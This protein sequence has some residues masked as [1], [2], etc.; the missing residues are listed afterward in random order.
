MTAPHKSRSASRAFTL[1]E[2]LVVISIIALLIGITFPALGQ[3]RES[4]R[5]VKCLANLR[6]IGQGVA[7]YMDRSKGLLPK[8]RPLLDVPVNTGRP[9]DP[10][11]TEILPEYLDVEVPRK[12]NQSDPNSFY[13]TADVFKCPSDRTSDS[14]NQ[15]WEPAWRTEGISY[16]YFPGLLMLAAE[17]LAVRDKQL[18]VSKAYEKGGEKKPLPILVDFGDWHKL[19]KTGPAKNALQFPGFNADWAKELTQEETGEIIEDAR[20]YGG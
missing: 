5:R 11:L 4:S 9:E 8:V 6:S 13:I 20:R 14:G 16:E 12:E 19:R 18:G 15:Q 2:L 17:M 3:A 7:M 1:I 10:A